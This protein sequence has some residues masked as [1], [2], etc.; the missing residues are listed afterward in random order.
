VLLITDKNH[1]LLVTLHHLLSCL[2]FDAATLQNG[3]LPVAGDHP[4]VPQQSQHLVLKMST[5]QL[6]DNLPEHWVGKA[7][8]Q[9]RLDVFWSLSQFESRFLLQ[10]QFKKCTTKK[11]HCHAVRHW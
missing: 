1:N 2:P 10:T 6:L 11:V 7:A 5:E 8:E 9:Q 3:I 4:D